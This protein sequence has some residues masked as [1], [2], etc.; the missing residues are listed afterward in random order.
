MLESGYKCSPFW[1]K[2]ILIL[3]APLEIKD[4]AIIL[5]TLK[6]IEASLSIITKFP[7]HINIHFQEI[8][9]TGAE[10]PETLN[11]IRPATDSNW[12]IMTQKTEEIPFLS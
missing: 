2:W 4:H 10:I 6:Q 12:A 9:T 1:E 5:K 11:T 3:R 7:T 8:T